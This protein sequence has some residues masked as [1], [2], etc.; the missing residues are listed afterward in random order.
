MATT[1]PPEVR[2]TAG[3]GTLE[4]Y[5]GLDATRGLA[6]MGI[7][8]MNIYGFAAPGGAYFNPAAFGGDSGIDWL[9]WA[10][11]FVFVDSKMRG[12][13]SMLFGAS[14]LLVIQRAMATERKPAAAH[15]SR[16]F[17]LLIFGLIHFYFIWWGDI[18]TLYAMCGAILFL[19]RNLSVKALRRWAIGFL[20]VSFLF[21]GSQAAFLQMAANGQ[22]PPEAMNAQMEEGLE[23]IDG[24]FGASPERVARDLDHFN[25]SYEQIMGNRLYDK[26]W[27]PVGSFFQ[28]GLETL[29]LMLIGMALFKSGMLTGTW[30]PARYRK[31]AATCFAIAVPALIVLT[32]YQVGSGYA[33]TVI[34]GSSIAWSMPFDVV[35][36]IGW[37]ALAMLMVGRFA[38]S[39]GVARL[40]ATGRMAFTNYLATSIVMTTVFYGY[41]LGLYGDVSRAGLYLFVI[42]MWAAMLAWSKPWLDRFNYGPLE[43][44][45]RSLSRWSVQPMLR[46]SQV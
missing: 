21:M 38:R 24:F 44:L 4:R 32:W 22:L 34:F 33:G 19:F 14:T 25:G 30:E 27:Q 31:W 18:L 46:R 42:G 3:L 10:F 15:Y 9:V 43:W 37:A 11:N 16:M 6:V 29:G 8:A 5:T 13:F 7:L 41:G 40:A 26:T 23:Q 28:I 20:A 17:W 2:E 12:L 45:W 1:T 35:M 36:T 39:P